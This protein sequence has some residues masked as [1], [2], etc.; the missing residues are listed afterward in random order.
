MPKEIPLFHYTFDNVE[1]NTIYD[2]MGNYPA[3]INDASIVDGY[4]GNGLLGN[5]GRSKDVYVPGINVNNFDE[6]SIAWHGKAPTD[7]FEHYQFCLGQA[8]DTYYNSNYGFFVAFQ[9]RYDRLR[10]LVGDGGS[11]GFSHTPESGFSF[12]LDWH[13]YVYIVKVG[14]PIKLYIDGNFI[15]EGSN[16]YVKSGY[17]CELNIG[18]FNG[19]FSSTYARSSYVDNFR[20]YN[21]VIEEDEVSLIYQFDSK[22]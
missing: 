11:G 10:V 1:G 8:K 15:G 17:S 4:S 5:N 21:K 14:Q 9:E 12:F 19:S 20:F 2:E 13:H 6:F 16:N 3:I 22:K 18:S 7:S